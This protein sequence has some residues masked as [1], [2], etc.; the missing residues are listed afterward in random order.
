MKLTQFGRM[1]RRIK[2]ELTEARAIKA[3]ALAQM[4]GLLAAGASQIALIES[5]VITKKMLDVWKKEKT[6][7]G[8]PCD[9]T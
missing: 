7:D 2:K 9:L 3:A 8:N 4:S 1:R 5:A 6:T